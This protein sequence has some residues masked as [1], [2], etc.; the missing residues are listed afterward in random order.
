[1]QAG[2]FFMKPMLTWI[3]W[4]LA[5]GMVYSVLIRQ[6]GLAEQ[7]EGV[8][9]A[10]HD[11]TGQKA[12]ETSFIVIDSGH[13]FFDGGKIGAGGTEEKEINLA[14][15]K[16]VRDNLEMQGLNVRMTRENDQVLYDGETPSDKKEDMRKRTALMNARGCLLAVSIHQNSFTE[17][18]YKGA[19]VFYYKPSEESRRLA[20]AIQRSLIEFQDPENTRQEKANEDYY[21]LRKETVPTVICECGFLSNPQ[22]EEL[23]CS[24]AY[25]DKTAWAISVGILRYLNEKQENNGN[26]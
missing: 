24:E 11:M 10:F 6:S 1:M 20:S 25:Q 21:I 2:F 3:L 23:L 12:E 26:N 19:Q 17:K 16:K 22:E 18:K 8:K 13:G 4:C 5:I 7:I 15:A 14:I 9:D